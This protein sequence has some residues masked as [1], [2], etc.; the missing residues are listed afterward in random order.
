MADR[1]SAGEGRNPARLAAPVALLA[2]AVAVA[3][4]IQASSSGS[5][6]TSQPPMD[7]TA[8][9]RSARHA[10]RPPPTSYVV[11]S[12]DTLSLIAARTHVSLA[13]IMRLNPNV[14]PQALQAG[15]RLKLSP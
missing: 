8:L 2:A 7:S 10:V 11:R 5:S 3:V 15:Q 1:S 12:G 6:G 13:T 9:R 14:D 4:V